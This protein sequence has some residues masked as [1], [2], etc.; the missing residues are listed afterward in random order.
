[1][2][3]SCE[4]CGAQYRISDEK[5]GPRGAKVRCKRCGAPIYLPG[6]ESG[7]GEDWQEDRE[8]A[9]LSQD[10]A[11]EAANRSGDLAENGALNTASAFGSVAAQLADE[12]AQP[13][14]ARE[15]DDETED[16]TRVDI[17]VPGELM[18]KLSHPVKE[19]EVE[20]SAADSSLLGA[21]EV[22]EEVEAALSALSDDVDVHEDDGDAE[23]DELDDEN[24]G[25]RALESSGSLDEE[26]AAPTSEHDI[27]AAEVSD[28]FARLERSSVSYAQTFAQGVMPSASSESLFAA[29]LTPGSIDVSEQA[30]SSEAETTPELDED[31]SPSFGDGA[32]AEIGIAFSQ[33]FSGDDSN[34]FEDRTIAASAP[35]AP[36]EAAVWYA[37]IE[38]EQVGPLTRSELEERWRDGSLHEGSLAWKQGMDDW[39]PIREMD[40]LSS[41]SAIEVERRSESFGVQGQDAAP[42]AEQESA[43]HEAEGLYEEEGSFKPSAAGALASLAAVEFNRHEPYGDDANASALNSESAL[44][45]LLQGD[46]KKTSASEFGASE[47]SV[48]RVRPIPRSPEARTSVPL[49][50]PTRDRDFTKIILGASLALVLVTLIGVLI[51]VAFG[52]NEETVSQTRVAVS[53]QKSVPAK[54]NPPPPA[55]E[56]PLTASSLPPVGSA[57]KPLPEKPEVKKEKT[58][59]VPKDRA[60]KPKKLSGKAKSKK[61]GQAGALTS[62]SDD[63]L[64][65]IA[66]TLPKRKKRKRRV[67]KNL[68]DERPYQLDDAALLTVLRRYKNDAARCRRLQRDS[69]SR[70]EGEMRVVL[71][72]EN[73][74]KVLKV[75]IQPRRFTG[76]AAAK[77]M[78]RAA[79]RWRFPAFQKKRDKVDFPLRIRAP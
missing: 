29:G 17:P 72:I 1:M 71:T 77:C 76:S 48:S 75:G 70:L 14:G 12:M 74:G 11:F 56:P 37:A 7:Q 33:M 59:G 63:D 24:F 54:A 60:L 27:R 9:L 47:M 51:F 46:E 39:L 65:G 23:Q 28:E 26:D 73:I 68:E 41:L 66:G 30:L 35:E 45:K 10:L 67:V 21:S 5:V 19:P 13:A 8:T 2:E 43:L 6:S 55:Q 36:T 78:V 15:A 22:D 38:D 16:E 62:V 3:F 69:G 57:L 18:E 50:D 40:E 42:L 61:R 64:L 79:K 34:D 49:R 20:S 44:E 58:S 32:E 52:R 53:P 25:V 31:L 4:S